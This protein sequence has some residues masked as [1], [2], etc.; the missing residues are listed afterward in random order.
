M[1]GAA[2]RQTGGG[3]T[4]PGA[5]PPDPSVA[6]IRWRAMW[7]CAGGSLRR[8]RLRVMPAAA[9]RSARPMSRRLD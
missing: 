3:H 1:C 5:G 6:F 8:S 4:L 7:S 9:D 2:Y